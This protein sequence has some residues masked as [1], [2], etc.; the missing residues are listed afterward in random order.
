MGAPFNAKDA[1]FALTFGDGDGGS[2]ITKPFIAPPGVLPTFTRAGATATTVGATGLVLKGIAA[3]VA[4]S[5][6]DPTTLAY[7]GYLP[8]G[9]RTNICLQS[10]DLGTTWTNV[11]STEATNVA[12]APDGTTTADRLIPDAAATDG[13]ML[14]TG[15]TLTAGSAY[16]F[17]VFAKTSVL[18][19]VQLRL[20]DN[21]FTNSAS[22]TF[23]TTTGA[24]ESAAAAAGTWTAASATAKQYQSGYWRFTLTATATTNAGDR[25]TLVCPDTGDGT[26][27]ILLWGMDVE[28]GAF[29]STYIP[30]TVASVTRNADVLSYPTSPWLSQSVGTIFAQAMVRA[31]NASS[32]DIL[33]INDGTGN[34]RY[35]M[36]LNTT[37]AIVWL[38]IDGG[39][40]QFSLTSQALTNNAA[41]KVA[42]VY[43]VNDFALTANAG[44]IQTDVAGTLPTV[45]QIE[46]GLS[47][48]GNNLFSTISSTCYFP[49]R[50]LNAELIQMSADGIVFEFDPVRPSGGIPA[51]FHARGPTAEDKRRS[52]VKFGLEKEAEKV[53]EQVAK[54]QVSRRETDQQK[55][56][57]ELERE[58]MLQGI[59]FDSRYLAALNHERERLI[60]QA[61]QEA[62]IRAQSKRDIQAIIKLAQQALEQHYAQIG[63]Q[64]TMLQAQF[65]KMNETQIAMIEK[66]AEE[67][68]AQTDKILN[69]QPAPPEDDRLQQSADALNSTT[70]Q[71]TSI[72]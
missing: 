65:A 25:C 13:A 53:I 44:A 36:N 7:L 23:N 21:G 34:E 61:K 42:G 35:R 54:S 37:P 71:L 38:G 63:E 32:G 3:N 72:K 11:N 39:V 29:A 59:E 33:G 20:G 5:F 64:V 24:V 4:R 57:E 50:R 15:L 6:Y 52:R 51:A 1:T 47:S 22:V 14:Q 27:G 31:D 28:L 30:T 66:F 48:A 41:V 17:S 26:N 55:R 10:E 46:I 69:R 60:A 43:A 16:T 12:I 9:A 70:E 8:E 40:S 62:R 58:L 49:T 56:F 2:V 19:S 68:F 67:Y 18:D 45:T